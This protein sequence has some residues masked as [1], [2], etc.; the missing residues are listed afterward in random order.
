M[1][2]DIMNISGLLSIL[3]YGLLLLQE[4]SCWTYHSSNYNMNY[5]E[6]EK[7][8]KANFTNLVAIQTK[9]EI[10][11]LNATL[12]ENA[13]HYWIGLRKINSE[14]RWVG[15]NKPLDKDA[16]NWAKGEP[17]GRKLNEDCVEIYIKRVKDSGKWNDER[18]SKKKAALCYTAS[19]KLDSCSGRG[20]CVETINNYTCN[21]DPG[22]YGRD[23]EYVRICEPPREPDHGILE[24][25][26][27]E[28]D[29]VYNSSCRVQCVEGY[30]PTVNEPIWC[31]SSGIWSTPTPMCKAVKCEM[32]PQP[33]NGF[34]NCSHADSELA[35]NSTCRFGCEEGYTL[36][37]SSQIQ[38]SSQGIWSAPIP[39]CEAVK[40]EAVSQ[41]ESGFVNCSRP[42]TELVFNSTCQFSCEEGYTLRGLSQIQCSSEGHWSAPISHCEM[43]KCE[44]IPQP[45]RGFV[46]CSH[47]DGET[48]NSTCQFSCEEGYILQGS[49]QIQCSSQGQWSAPIP[50]CKEVKC[51]A[52]QPPEGGFVNCSHTDTNL[53]F[54]S[55]CQF[56]CEEGYTLQGSSQIQCSS[57]G[58]WSAS[59][60]HCEIAK[61]ESL[62]APE[63]GFLNCT[64]PD[65]AY[66]TL[67]EV[68][69]M[70]GWML[71]GSYALQCLASGK[72]TA[73]L[74]TCEAAQ[75]QWDVAS[76]LFTATAATGASILSVGLLL[77]WLIKRIRRKV[78]KFIPASNYHSLDSE[79][80]FQSSA[81]LI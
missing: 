55:T 34:A 54:N 43:V 19:C 72:W 62:T 64:H 50:Q 70:D 46:N 10:S 22:F 11:Y 28:K 12:D 60:P 5:A 39:H 75:P 35:F 3:V 26:K 45:E 36:R 24:C 6:A 78:K 65:F 66:R 21:C 51:G 37:G 63:K 29:F 23:C 49:S 68:S 56:S 40:C 74:P 59:I 69:C 16:E 61:C 27:P 18:C 77:A 25:D 80:T 81:D 9:E 71:N 52:V 33:E 1:A 14:W 76:Y 7:W 67:C 17:N 41:P 8:C 58:H 32:V 20:E 79:G 47:T 42:E 44:A 48:V 13:N 4:C 15:T 30:K 57:K 53:V 2:R 31:T 73:G 38:C